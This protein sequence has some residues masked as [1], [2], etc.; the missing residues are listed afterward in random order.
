MR[1]LDKYLSEIMQH[2]KNAAMPI[3][4][5]NIPEEY[6]PTHIPKI[7]KIRNNQSGVPYSISAWQPQQAFAP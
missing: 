3:I 4:Q 1:F 6:H 5:A 7:R 2:T